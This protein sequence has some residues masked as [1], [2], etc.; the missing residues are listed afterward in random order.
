MCCSARAQSNYEY[1]VEILTTA[2]DLP[3]NSI[4][5]VTEDS[6]GFLWVGTQNGLARYDGYD[7]KTYY[8]R[9]GDTTSLAGRQVITVHI[10]AKGQLWAGG[11]WSDIGGVSRFDYATEKFSRYRHNPDDSNS[12]LSDEVASIISSRH[13]PEV[14]WIDSRHWPSG[15]ISGL[16]R[17]DQ[18]KGTYTRYSSKDGLADN[19]DHAML[20]DRDGTLWTGGQG[21][22]RRFNPVSNTFDVFVPYGES[23]QSDGA[24]TVISIHEDRAGQLWIGTN[25]GGLMGF[26]K[27]TRTFIKYAPQPL[28]ISDP[29]LTVGKI[30]EDRTGLLWIGTGGGLYTFDRKTEKYER[31]S[32]QPFDYLVAPT[33]VIY[34]DRSGVIWAGAGLAA[35]NQGL[36]KIERRKTSF[37]I[38]KHTSDDPQSISSDD[39]SSIYLDH[40]GMLWIGTVDPRL[41]DK[42]N[43]VNRSTGAVD[44]YPGFTVLTYQDRLGTLWVG[45]GCPPRLHRMQGGD[46][47]SFTR[48]EHDPGNANS[49]GGG[50]LNQILEDQAGNFWFA[51]WRSGLDRMDRASGTFTHFTPES[52]GLIDNGVLR[53]YEAPSQ[54]GILW[55]GTEDGLS[56]MDTRTEQFTNY[57]IGRSMMMLED[58]KGRFWVA[59]GSSG[60]Y[61]FDRV[62]GKIV[63][64]YTVED[65]LAHNI[66][67]SVFEDEDGFLWISTENGLSRFHPEEK[68]FVNF[69]VDDGLPDNRFIE[70]AKFQSPSGELFFGTPSGAVSFF[71][72]EV[73]AS[74]MAPSIVITAVRIEGD[75]ADVAGSRRQ[76]IPIMTRGAIS[77]S[78]EERDLRFEYTGIHFSR[79]DGTRYRYILEGYDTHWIDGGSERGVR[80]TKLTHGEYLFRV[81]AKNLGSDWE[82]TSLIVTILPPWWRTAWAYAL[83]ALLFAAAVFAVE[84]FQRER[85]VAR[86]R[87][88]AEREQARAIASTNAELQRALQHLTETQDQLVHSQKMASLGQLTAGIAHELKNPLNFVNNFAELST[89]LTGELVA[90]LDEERERLTP[91]NAHQLKGILDDLRMNTQK[92][93]E[94]GR[95]ADGIIRA[96]LDH[97]RTQPGG[98]DSVDLNG[99][100]DEYVNLAFHGMRARVPEFNSAIERKYDSTVGKVEVVPQEI[101]RVFLNLLDNAFYAVH[102][103]QASAGPGFTPTVWVETTRGEDYVEIRVKDNGPGVPHSVRDKIF[104]PFFTTK[105]AGSGTGLGL[106]LSYDIVVKGHRGMLT[107]EGEEGEGASFILRLPG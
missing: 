12:L 70:P 54:P 28:D 32:A 13:E 102:Q 18:A 38:Y 65:G 7:F 47:V 94:H 22:L 78:H 83:Y 5:A 75:D 80:Y 79:P 41:G 64:H 71:P 66:T 96:M 53:V 6:L 24:N 92:I 10:D 77:L 103:K 9:P 69:T 97:A 36:L 61:L 73:V 52:N 59:T 21:G 2:N 34:E 46:P 4:Y 19:F 39:I 37:T 76:E 40:E 25:G 67:Y 42:L 104:E 63:V 55:V 30:Y 89:E 33:G 20:I 72:R 16:T 91:V 105:P 88:R 87:L 62:A 43:R 3:S 101:G 29:T 58:S 48:Y 68:T 74:S 44:H 95:R 90:L 99:L 15:G 14:I 56:R 107:V 49:I 26:E 27:Q 84:R 81:A 31:F 57:D 85:L 11:G 60:L 50:C 23:V 82:E 106:S 17:F 98:R 93:N 8:P 51:I 86:E 100:L 1:H 35:F 45:G